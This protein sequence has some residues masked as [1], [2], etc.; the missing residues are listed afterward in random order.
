MTAAPAE[1]RARPGRT[2]FGRI[3]ISDRVVATLAAVAA[4]EVPDAGSA[5]SGM[6]GRSLGE[7]RAPGVRRTSLAGRPKTSARVDGARARVHVVLSV[8]WPASVAEVCAEVRHRV[9]ERIE[10]LTGLT[11]TDLDI[12]VT[13]LVTRS[14]PQPR[15]R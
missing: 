1:G 13:D 9:T 14:E 7:T 6:L 11:V 4:A 3:D 10:W 15:A 8:R 2:E 12:E 5:A